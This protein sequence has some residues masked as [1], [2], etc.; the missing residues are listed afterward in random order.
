MLG[1]NKSNNLTSFLTIKFFL[2]NTTV[3]VVQHT[4]YYIF[5]I[6]LCSF[7]SNELKQGGERKQD[8]RHCFHNFTV[9][10]QSDQT[11]PLNHKGKVFSKQCSLLRAQTA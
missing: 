1:D 11:L 10:V 6:C 3:H 2:I 8:Q 4:F 9:G 7:Q 5:A